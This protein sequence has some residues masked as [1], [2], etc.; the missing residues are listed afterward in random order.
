[1]MTPKSGWKDK[2]AIPAVTLSLLSFLVWGVLTTSGATHTSNSNGMGLSDVG[3]W[4]VPL[5]DTNMWY[6]G[7]AGGQRGIRHRPLCP[8]TL[9]YAGAW[10]YH[11]GENDAF[12]ND[13]HLGVASGQTYVEYTFYGTG[14]KVYG[15][16]GPQNGN[17]NIYIDN[18]LVQQN[19]STYNSTEVAQQ[20]LWQTNGL[21]PGKHVLKAV[22][23]A[24]ANGSRQVFD[25]FEDENTYYT[26]DVPGAL[27][28]PV[29]NWTQVNDNDLGYRHYDSN[30]LEVMDFHIQQLAAARVD[31]VLFD[32]TN[33]GMGYP[34]PYQNMMLSWW[35]Q[36]PAFF[37]ADV[38][39]FCQRLA[40]WN[41]DHNW[42]IRYAFAVGTGYA[43]QC[44]A[45]NDD[46]ATVL[47][48]VAEDV[49]R[50]FF[51]DS[52]YGGANYYQ[53]DGYPLL[54][55]HDGSVALAMSA[56]QSAQ[57]Y[58]TNFNLKPSGGTLSAGACGWWPAEL[59]LADEEVVFI[60]PGHNTHTGAQYGL[61]RRN[62]GSFYDGE[63][64][65]F[66][67][68][69]SWPS[70]GTQMPKAVLIGSFNEYIE[71]N[72]VWTADT[73]HVDSANPTGCADEVWLNS[74]A[75]IEPSMYW[76]ATLRNV[77]KLRKLGRS[78]FVSLWPGN[79]STNDIVGGQNGFRQTGTYAQGKFGQAF[80]LSGSADDVVVAN[81]AKLRLT[82]GMTL[83]CWV[84]PGRSGYWQNLISKW[85]A[86]PLSPGQ[87]S[88]V[89][90]L[91]P[92]NRVYVGISTN[93]YDSGAVSVLS[94]TSLAVD[95]ST[96]YHIT[97]TF[98]GQ[99]LRIYVNGL[100][101]GA[102]AV[103]SSGQATIFQGSDDLSVGAT[104]GGGVVSSF[105]GLIDE[106]CVYNRA[107]TSGEIMDDY[108]TGLGAVAWLP[109]ED[110]AGDIAGC[111]GGFLQG[112]V[113]FAQGKVTHDQGQEVRAFCF[114]NVGQAV[115]LLDRPDLDLSSGMTLEAWIKPS[116]LDAWQN[117]IAKWDG[118]VQS[119]SQK[120][121]VLAMNP[122]NQVYVG[123]SRDGTDQGSS[124]VTSTSSIP[125][126][127]WTHVAGSYDGTTLRIY[128]NGLEEAQV[129]CS[130]SIFQGNG[131]LGVG[132][133]VG[134][135][136]T[137]VQYPY[138]FLGSIDEPTVYP[139]S[140]TA[141]EIWSIYAAQNLS[142]SGGE[143]AFISDFDSGTLRNDYGDFVG[144]HFQVSSTPIAVSKLGRMMVSGNSGSHLL[145]LVDAA[146]GND[147]I[148]GS[149]TINMGGGTPGQFKYASLATPII[150]TPGSQYYLVSQESLSG[151][152]WYDIDTTL[153][154][155]SAGAVSEG[156]YGTGPG[157]W[158]S[159]GTAA[160]SYVPV[161]FTYEDMALPFVTSFVTSRA[162][163]TLRNDY[164]PY[165]GM[166]ID[167]GTNAVTV[168][169]LGRIMASGNAGSHVVKFVDA[170]TG[171]D[172]P[173]GSVTISMTGGSVGEF[174]YQALATPITL[175]AGTSYFLVSQEAV[176]GDLWHD[177]DTTLSSTSAASIAG[178]IYGSGPGA[179]YSYGNSG[180][181][182]VPVDFKY[183]SF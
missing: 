182:Y 183:C 6:R 131:D 114:T 10:V 121:Y 120:S 104:R 107:L 36:D 11:T 91:Y 179:W 162:L 31:F 3:M 18:Q 112:N 58:A 87:R 138:E 7:G 79:D 70:Q 175:S 148:G 60:S 143:V 92:D 62:S 8:R 88:Y 97:G 86:V 29:T 149:V 55:V 142:E 96:W 151:D 41:S 71:D 85:D 106:A 42:K 30:D 14:I 128:V 83:E 67:G 152:Y 115:R 158:Y 141:N 80:S 127:S 102:V 21:I 156:V 49:Y 74:S 167:I 159:Y 117:I 63:W 133:V 116:R 165:V 9:T 93:G 172:V 113:T 108:K 25:K 4:Y 155:T 52:S 174:K 118:C 24:S 163:G 15:K 72:A 39:A 176:G 17:L 177:I 56:I 166:W 38:Q 66:G 145:K 161:N 135:C 43:G 110:S 146:T 51:Q 5:Y 144:M 81:S 64:N 109:G 94:T 181:G 101:E 170:A 33:G 46:R 73:S 76:D 47:Q 84:R 82:T 19:W 32:T 160:H 132:A 13:Y 16:K 140:L 68:I 169:E 35:C 37:R 20:L 136:S 100:C 129:P 28:Y 164:G 26:T 44:D 150:L 180:R 173:G 59:P 119:P 23:V 48:R 95:G 137:S 171:V 78:G 99:N 98:D 27:G 154:T 1:M 57:G 139:R 124:S 178:G 50:N 89:L 105:A 54:V 153:T 168:T 34:D 122:Q 103:V 130:G 12:G 75:E 90:G 125:A 65:G 111:K 40:Y 22:L 45:A 157:S 134:G 2:A 126:G 69:F 77:N 123:F 147:L 53:L 61:A